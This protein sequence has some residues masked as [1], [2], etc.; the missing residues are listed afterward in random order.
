MKN[1]KNTD[2]LSEIANN[3]DGGMSLLDV[4][5]KIASLNNKGFITKEE[6]IAL[7]AEAQNYYY[8]K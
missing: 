6:Q 1:D 5:S 3:I 4:M 8:S 2:Y 7:T